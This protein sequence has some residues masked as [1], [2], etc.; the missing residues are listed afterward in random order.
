MDIRIVI[1]S[2]HDWGDRG[3]LGGQ[4]SNP[5]R[6]RFFLHSRLTPLLSVQFHRGPFAVPHSGSLALEGRQ[7]SGKPPALN[8]VS[9]L[10]IDLDP[11][12]SRWPWVGPAER[13]DLYR[14]FQQVSLEDQQNDANGTQ[15]RGAIG[16]PFSREVIGEG[17]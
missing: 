11:I 7:S 2:G 16:R 10:K 6:G 8:S 15:G 1:S 17:E 13:S 12:E 14:Y 4:A 3:G 5:D 9:L